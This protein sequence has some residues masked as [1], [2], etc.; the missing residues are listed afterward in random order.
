MDTDSN[1]RTGKN[2]SV[3]KMKKVILR[4]RCVTIKKYVDPWAN[5]KVPKKYSPLPT[6]TKHV[7]AS[8]LFL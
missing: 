6:T 3:V 2:C 8:V 4:Y 7:L 1:K 5:A